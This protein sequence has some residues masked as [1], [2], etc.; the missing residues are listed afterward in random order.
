DDAV[1]AVVLPRLL[2]DGARRPRRPG[3]DP[4]FQGGDL[5]SGEAIL[6]LGRHLAFALVQHGVHQ[7]AVLAVVRHERRSGFT[8][9]ERG[10]P[11]AQIQPAAKLR[12]VAVA[13]EASLL[14]KRG[15]LLGEQSLRFFGRLL[16]G[17]LRH[18]AGTHG[19]AKRAQRDEHWAA[20]SSVSRHKLQTTRARGA[21]QRTSESCT[22]SPGSFLAAPGPPRTTPTLAP[23]PPRPSRPR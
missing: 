2:G 9:L 19:E 3:V 11:R 16:R 17:R 23:N 8:A 5:V 14:E 18:G 4:S 10:L 21:D 6:F 15:D 7:Q 12:I 22:L 1:L 13:T 20:D